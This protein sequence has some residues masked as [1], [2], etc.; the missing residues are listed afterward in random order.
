MRTHSARSG[1]FKSLGRVAAASNEQMFCGV[2][3]TPE[4]LGPDVQRGNGRSSG[5]W[6]APAALHCLGIATAAA[7]AIRQST[8]VPISF[9]GGMTADSSSGS[10]STCSM[11]MCSAIPGRCASA[12]YR[13]TAVALSCARP[14]AASNDEPCLGPDSFA[15]CRQRTVV[16][17]AGDHAALSGRAIN[18]RRRADASFD[19]AGP[20]RAVRP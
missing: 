18:S 4:R 1:A 5:L 8:P 12:A 16:E 2:T 7:W 14:A 9:P 11:P 20:R 3:G 6:S 17:Q 13:H 15:E 10:I 19:W